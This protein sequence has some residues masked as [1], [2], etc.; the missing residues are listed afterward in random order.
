M[1]TFGIVVIEALMSRIPVLASDIEVMKELSCNGKYFELF[2][3]QNAIELAH[4]IKSKYQNSN[5]KKSF[6]AAEYTS[7]N[8]SYKR[9]IHDLK[10][11]YK[12]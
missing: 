4:L 7:E 8:Y 5:N 10:N 12:E 3:K 6:Y 2:E 1:D 11:K 9:Y